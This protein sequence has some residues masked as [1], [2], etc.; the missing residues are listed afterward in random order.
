M[1]FKGGSLAVIMGLIQY[2]TTSGML[3]NDELDFKIDYAKSES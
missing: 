3:L 2:Y 1:H